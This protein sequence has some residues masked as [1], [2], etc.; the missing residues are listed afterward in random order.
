MSRVPTK[1]EVTS[2]IQIP[3]SE[4]ELSYARAGGPGGQHVNKTSSKVILRWSLRASVALGDRDRA[5]LEE[6]LASRLTGSGEL[7][8]ASDLHREQS[9]NVES[10]LARF[11]A[12]LREGL[13]RPKARRK[14]KPSRGA[15]QRRLDAKKLRGDVKRQRRQ[16][17]RDD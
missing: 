4:I 13:H 5:W 2:R 10:V 17:G 1:I 9:R 11:V 3:G 6:R 8:L 16:P 15:R 12:I 7:V 14:T